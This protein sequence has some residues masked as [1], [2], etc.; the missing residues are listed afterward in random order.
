MNYRVPVRARTISDRNP[1]MLT[2]MDFHAIS[3]NYPLPNI[4]Y[5]AL[6]KSV[7]RAIMI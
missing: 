4:F 2:V 5:V 7:E 1:L 3:E 6:F